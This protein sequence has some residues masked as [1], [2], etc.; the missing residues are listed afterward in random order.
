MLE[1]KVLYINRLK[2]KQVACIQVYKK[3]MPH[4]RDN[5]MQPLLRKDTKVPVSAKKREVCLEAYCCS[6]P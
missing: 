6:T 1:C 2:K 4:L 3:E 5:T